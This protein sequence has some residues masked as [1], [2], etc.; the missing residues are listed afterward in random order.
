[1]GAE[2][3]DPYSYNS[4]DIEEPPL[5]IAPTLRRI[6]PGLLLTAAIVGTGELIATTRLGA[7]VGYVM[8]WAVIG[9]CLLKSI[10]QAV[11]GRYTIATGET[12]LRALN[13]VPGPRA[14]NINWVVW[15]W[16]VLMLLSLVLI[17]AMYA[18]VAQVLVQFV[19]EVAP[20]AWVVLLT[21]ITLV[22]LLWG[23]YERVEFLAVWMVAIFTF[24]TICAAA[25]LMSEPDY[26]SWAQMAEGMTFG[27]PE[28]GI[29]VAIAVFGITGVNAGE[30][31]AYTYWCVEKGYARHVGPRE[32]SDAWRR[33]ANGWIRVMH[34]DIVVSMVV[35]T[36]AT[37]AF[38]M[39]GAGVL[40]TMGTVPQG[41]ETIAV[42]SN[43]YTQTMGRFGLGVFY[44]GAVFA[45]YSTVFAAT[46]ANSRIFSDMLQ[47]VGLFE[48]SDYAARLRYQ[49][50]FV[51]ALAIIPCIIYFWTG[52]PVGMIK[53]GGMI[54]GLMLPVLA[55]SVVYLRHRR[56]PAEVQPGVPAT[57][58][59][60]FA[61]ALSLVA[62][63][64]FVGIQVGLIKG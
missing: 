2:L 5:G 54:L 45:L 52:E 17:G 51:V 44:V 48:R 58:L 8:L 61:A 4:A 63:V 41:N 46:A 57:V 15:T 24:M 31:S 53:A 33:R 60:W 40:H 9:S 12:G 50:M 49:R 56:L 20:G 47:L 18:G 64:G 25:V 7:E 3:K 21:A 39:L 27:L 11:W 59:L 29:A 62:M 19:P 36:L 14:R 10:I 22:V 13:H 42:L 26:F 28:K 43:M 23:T 37:V 16:G 30:L 55:W 38:Y 34:W 6:G 1:M 35:Y 32:D